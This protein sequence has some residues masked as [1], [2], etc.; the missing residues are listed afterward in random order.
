MSLAIQTFSHTIRNYIFVIN[1][2]KMCSLQ[3][4]QGNGPF[5]IAIHMAL[6]SGFLLC[7]SFNPVF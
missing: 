5:W 3:T 4:P 6:P 7:F 2:F 1:L